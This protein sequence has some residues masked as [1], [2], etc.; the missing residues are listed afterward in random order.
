M[1]TGTVFVELIDRQQRLANLHVLD[2]AVAT[3]TGQDDRASGKLASITGAPAFGEFA[4]RLRRVSTVTCV[5]RDPCASMNVVL[6]KLGNPVL[7]RSMALQALSSRKIMG[8][9][10]GWKIVGAGVGRQ[11]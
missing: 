10:I 2:V 6:P 11:P 1:L 4:V 9:G 8:N 7:R 3:P 5:A